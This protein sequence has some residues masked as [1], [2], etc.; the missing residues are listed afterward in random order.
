M[1]KKLS[2]K[3][4][5]IIFA[6]LLVVLAV[7]TAILW[8]IFWKNADPDS[9]PLTVVLG[10]DSDKYN[11]Y[12]DVTLYGAV[13][14]DGKD[15]TDAFIKAAKTG[16]GVY[17]PLGTFDIKKTVTLRGQNLKGAG[18][19]RSVIRFNGNGTIV[20]VKG[21]T[22]VD[23]IT[24]TFAEKNITGK[25]KAGEQVAIKDLGL[26]NGAMLRAVKLYNVGTGFLSEQNYETNLSFMVESLIID[27]F[28]HKAIEMKNASTTVFRTTEIG[29]A[30]TSVEEAV[31]LGGSFT[32]DTVV[33][34]GTKCNYPIVF[35]NCETAVINTVVFNGAE[36]KSGSLIKSISSVISMRTVT[37]KA[38]KATN[39]VK[40][41]DNAKYGETMG[42][43]ISLW[44]NSGKLSIDDKNLIKC[45]SN[46]SQ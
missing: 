44:S 22:L 33:F 18:M 42:N 13:A 14:N 12:A 15:D 9:I 23:D 37:V 24:L 17:V 20:E 8:P 10:S 5:V 38:T 21:A 41:E 46:I 35:N 3:A 36:A 30:Y 2:L 29:E 11:G 39:L 4:F 32:L 19:D 45:E 7:A 34:S 6:S 16:A 28:S 31:A 43:I 1:K 40:I 26:S 27:K 25:E